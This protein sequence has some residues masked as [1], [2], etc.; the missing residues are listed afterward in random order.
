M[1]CSGSRSF[2]PPS[3]RWPTGPERRRAFS[4]SA[5]P[6]RTSSR[7]SPRASR[8]A[9]GSWTSRDSLLGIKTRQELLSHPKLGAS[10]EGFAIEQVLAACGHEDAW[11]WAT[12]SGAEL[13]LLLF[14]HGKAWGLEFKVGDGPAMTKSLHIALEDLKLERAWIVHPGSKRYPVHEKVE[15]LPLADVHLLAAAMER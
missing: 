11:F 5:V 10:W 12:H 3:A 14:R 13:D 6:R 1:K 9:W 4:S 7:A 8:S 15:A 2:S